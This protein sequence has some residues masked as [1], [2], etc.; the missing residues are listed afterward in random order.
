MILVLEAEFNKVLEADP[1]NAAAY[2]GKGYAHY[3]E[4]DHAA[5]TEV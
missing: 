1:E 3:L 5:S 4:G 2:Y